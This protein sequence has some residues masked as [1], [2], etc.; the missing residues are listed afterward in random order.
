MRLKL[1]VLSVLYDTQCK[2][3]EYKAYHQCQ[4]EMTPISQVRGDR[5]AETPLERCLAAFCTKLLVGL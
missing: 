2:L 4:R 3:R 1:E 5:G